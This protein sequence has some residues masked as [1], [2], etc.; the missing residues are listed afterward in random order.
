[1]LNQTENLL[2]ND[3][4]DLDNFTV[5]QIKNVPAVYRRRDHCF[6]GS[7]LSEMMICLRSSDRPLTLVSFRLTLRNSSLESTGMNKEALT[8]SCDHGYI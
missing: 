3:D 2:I 6:R 4:K 1:M 7:T 8:V 5:T